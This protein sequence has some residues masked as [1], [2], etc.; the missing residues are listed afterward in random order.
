MGRFHKGQSFSF[1]YL[2]DFHIFDQGRRLYLLQVG[3]RDNCPLLSFISFFMNTVPKKDRERVIANHTSKKNCIWRPIY[4]CVW[5]PV[6]LNIREASK[7]FFVKSCQM[8]L[9]G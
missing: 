2:F 5:R 4:I 7:S 6:Q 3:G 1:Q 9:I 8:A